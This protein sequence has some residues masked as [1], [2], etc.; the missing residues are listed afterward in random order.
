MK[1]KIISIIIL[2]CSTELISLEAREEK[3]VSISLLT[4]LAKSE[5]T[6]SD[7]LKIA[8]GLASLWG[9]HELSKI[10]DR[11]IYKHYVKDLLSDINPT[12]MKDI[13]KRAALRSTNYGLPLLN[14]GL[15][16]TKWVFT[17]TILITSLLDYC[18]K[19]MLPITSKKS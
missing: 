19:K 11:K 6:I 13:I 8:G 4:P 10:L 12:S 5:K 2:L 18:Q 3:A 1:K 15:S 16:S 17:G 14:V 7:N 9:T